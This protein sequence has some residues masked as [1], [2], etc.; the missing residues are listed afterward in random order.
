M[1]NTIQP[2]LKIQIGLGSRAKYQSEL[3]QSYDEAKFALEHPAGNMIQAIN[4]DAILVSY[5]FKDHNE[6][7][8]YPLAL[9]ELKAKFDTRAI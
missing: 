3:R 4:H 2:K 9:H 5:L 8:S 6:H 1:L 7:C